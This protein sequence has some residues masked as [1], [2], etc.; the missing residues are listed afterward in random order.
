MMLSMRSIAVTAT[1]TLGL[2]IVQ[3]AEARDRPF[4]RIAIMV[5]ASGSYQERQAEAIEKANIL[6]GGMAERR[7][8]RWDKPDEIII[9]SLDAA[10]EVIWR[11]TPEKLAETDRNEWVARFKGRA[12]YAACT[13]VAR[14]LNLA[15]QELNAGTPLPTNRFLFAFSD[16]VDEQPV[17]GVSK[18]AAP[19]SVPEQDIA[20]EELKPLRIAVFWLPANQKM[21]WDG[22]MKGHGLNAYRLF[23]IS[24]SAVNR[25]DLPEPAKREVTPE[26]KQQS[27]DV[28]LGW[29][30]TIGSMLL[31]LTIG[32]IAVALLI[33]LALYGRRG[34]RPPPR[35]TPP[36]TGRA[37][38]AVRGPVPPLRIPPR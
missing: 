6:L 35:P 1:L 9:I 25:I 11:G 13:D 30:G 31:Y 28:L 7:V 14:G 37:G 29:A 23:S 26:Q 10:P 22:A 12:D 15:A 32:I 17:Q 2:A 3:P 21:A 24:E 33:G 38:V 34:R 8:K 16:L 36:A 18:C 5:D 19:R 20:W 27:R 4:N